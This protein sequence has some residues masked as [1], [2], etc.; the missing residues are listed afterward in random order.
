MWCSYGSRN[1]FLRDARSRYCN[2]ECYVI[3]LCETGPTREGSTSVQANASGGILWEP[4]D[5][6]NHSQV[7]S[8]NAVF[9]AHVRQ[10]LPCITLQI[11]KKMHEEGVNPDYLSFLLALQACDILIEEASLSAEGCLQLIRSLHTDLCCTDLG[12]DV[13]VG[14]SLLKLYARCGRMLEAEEVFET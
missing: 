3:S 14:T 7:V 13:L 6:F 12:S 10:C 5:S 4:F 2:L 9:S 1:H 8:W 11:D